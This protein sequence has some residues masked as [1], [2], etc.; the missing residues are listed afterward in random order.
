MSK[1]LIYTLVFSPDQVSNAYVLMNLVRGL[2]ELGHEIK[3]L[4][5]TPHYQPTDKSEQQLLSPYIGSWIFK[6]NFE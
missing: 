5:T 4:T 6:S 3:I 2:K 1:I